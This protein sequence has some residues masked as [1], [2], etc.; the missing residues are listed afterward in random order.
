MT[1]RGVCFDLFN[2]LVSVGK[3]PEHVGPFTADILGLDH[4][5]WRNAC[6]G[7]AHDICAPSDALENLRRMAHQ[8]DAFFKAC[9]KVNPEVLV[10]IDS[11]GGKWL[12][13]QIL[14]RWLLSEYPGTIVSHYL[15]TAHVADFRK[16]GARNM[17]VQINPCEAGHGIGCHLFLYFDDTIRSL[18]DIVAKRVRYVSLAGRSGN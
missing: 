17:M 16:I 11:I 15:D 10:Y 8:L 9:K 3:V 1:I 6:F 2:T 14:H 18:K 7:D 12:K 13:P 4:E 5:E